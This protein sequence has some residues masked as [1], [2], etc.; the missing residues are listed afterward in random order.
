V[1]DPHDQSVFA[2]YAVTDQQIA[3]V[4]Q[5]YEAWHP[6][7]VASVGRYDG[8]LSLCLDSQNRPH[9]SFYDFTDETLKYARWNGTQWLIETLDECSALYLH[10]GISMALEAQDHPHIAYMSNDEKLKY[11][12]FNGSS[13]HLD[14]IYDP[15]GV[16]CMVSLCLDTS[17][18]SHIAL[19]QQIPGPPEDSVNEIVYLISNGSTWIHDLVATQ[20]VGWYGVAIAL[21][22]QNDHPTIIF[23]HEVPVSF[24]DS[25]YYATKDHWRSEAAE[26]QYNLTVNSPYGNPQGQGWYPL[27]SLATVSITTPDGVGIQH[28]F[29]GWSGD[30]TASSPTAYVSMYQDQTVTANW[31]DDSTQLYGI[32]AA[33]LVIACVTLLLER[34][35]RTTL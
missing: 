20:E 26:I 13:W 17:D 15:P 22:P 28:V 11:A 30:I 33:I 7:V 19:L 23:Q 31:I 4:R 29:T 2:Y 6:E 35:M 8:A 16:V 9:I 1:M 27:G 34:R 10:L 21:N 25:L 14:Q 12:T 3:C 18:H 32:L 5:R 24:E